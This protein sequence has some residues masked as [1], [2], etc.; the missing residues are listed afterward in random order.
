[1]INKTQIYKVI[2]HDGLF[3][4]FWKSGEEE[5]SFFVPSTYE[6]KF[7]TVSTNSGRSTS[8]TTEDNSEE[9]F[10]NVAIHSLQMRNF[11]TEDNKF[12]LST[13]EAGIYYPRIWRGYYTGNFY[14]YYNAVNPYIEYKNK[15]LQSVTAAS[16]LFDYLVD[17]FRHI[18]PSI[19]NY[20]TFG[21]KIRELLILTCTEIESSWRAI[22]EGNTKIENRKT[23]YNTEDY[24][25]VKKPLHLDE[26]S[27]VL[28][29]Y[30]DLEPFSPFKEWDNSKPTQSLSWYDSYNA[31]K[32]N[33]EDKFSMATLSNLLNAMA[34]LHIMQAA[35][36]GVEIYS[37]L[38]DNR[39][40]PFQIIKYPKFNAS[41]LYMPSIDEN[42]NL[43]AGLYFEN[44]ST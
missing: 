4:A 15:Y 25:K 35:Q 33:R 9:E 31:V 14:G 6:P 12:Y 42:K 8:I 44:K 11:Y 32:H 1:M 2:S 40:S 5:I 10:F 18:E 34:A 41:D 19:D 21:H 36:W 16:S 7:F 26:W 13:V 23:R 22:L 20:K 29:D 3:A 17:I 39:F 27:V 28:K 43:T 38:H 37:R 30:P 24:F